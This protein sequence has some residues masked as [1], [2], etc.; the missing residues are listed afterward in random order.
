MNKKIIAVGA[1]GGSGTR[2]IAQVLIQAGIFMGDDLNKPNDNLFFTRLLKNP[3][4]YKK[5]SLDEKNK[6]LLS[7]KNYME[8]GRI[9]LRDLIVYYISAYTN[10]T[11]SSEL[12]F[13][14]DVFK[15]LFSKKISRDIWGWKEPN[16]QIFV[17]EIL[18]LFPNLKYIHILRSGLDMAFSNNKQQLK[19]WG[20]KYQIYLNGNETQNELAVKQLDYWI[21]STKDVIAKSK[22][23]ENR[24]LMVRHSEFCQSPQKEIDRLLQ[25]CEITVPSVKLKELYEIPS[26]PS[27]ANRYKNYDLTIFSQEQIQFVQEMGFEVETGAN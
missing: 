24:F 20:W 4:W 23:F 3:E 8:N 22:G 5:A 26:I 19:N 10:P 6:R 7:F 1:L 12:K 27:S 13:Y 17:S 16:T 11:Y 9:S 2:A 15:L 25:F 18:N 21:E 14:Q